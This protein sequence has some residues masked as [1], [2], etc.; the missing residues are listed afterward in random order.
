M[1]DSQAN[2]SQC[3]AEETAARNN[4]EYVYL[5]LKVQTVLKGHGDESGGQLDDI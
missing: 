2:V 3:A 5:T 1:S 4:V